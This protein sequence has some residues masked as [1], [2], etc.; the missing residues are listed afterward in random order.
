MEVHLIG[1][2][3]MRQPP[4]T[5]P[6]TKLAKF[7]IVEKVAIGIK[8]QHFVVPLVFLIISGIS[9]ILD[10]TEGLLV[11]GSNYECSI[12]FKRLQP[13]TSL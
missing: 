3:D 13:F 12:N 4:I 5:K 2:R 7:T 10:L 6:L 8:I 9:R 1:Q 11:G